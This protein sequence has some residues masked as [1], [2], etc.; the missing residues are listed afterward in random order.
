MLGPRCS[1]QPS[2][3]L[4]RKLELPCLSSRVNIFLLLGADVVIYGRARRHKH[5]HIRSAFAV[6]PSL[7]SSKVSSLTFLLESMEMPVAL[8]ECCSVEALPVH[9]P[10]TAARPLAGS[11][12]R[13]HFH[14]VSV[15][16]TAGMSPPASPN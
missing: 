16:R 5:V 1:Y 2:N 13:R 9:S 3:I 6:P 4:L 14:G 12:S 7:P 11:N 8:S 10:P 15:K